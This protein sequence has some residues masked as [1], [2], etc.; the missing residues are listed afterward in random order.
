M[1]QV[2]TVFRY[3]NFEGEFDVRDAD[4]AERFE[5]SLEEMR[6]EEKTLPK[7]G[8]NSNIIRAN[9]KLI[10]DFFDRCFEEGAGRAICGEKDNFGKCTEAY[11]AFL[12]L[13]QGQSK[14][15]SDIRNTFS[16]YSNREQRRKQQFG[17]P[18]NGGKP[19]PVK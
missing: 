9:C 11:M 6:K 7:T 1:S 16:Q 19:A 5:S 10:K 15:M 8:R 4:T 12:D 13:I 18:H 17:K 2:E 3:N 14:S